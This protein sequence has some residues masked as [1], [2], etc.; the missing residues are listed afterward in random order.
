ML[1]KL[2]QKVAQRLLQS[3]EK[4]GG[5][6]RRQTSRRSRRRRS[7][8]TNGLVANRSI[9][10]SMVVE[11]S[12][13]TPV[14]GGPFLACRSCRVLVWFNSCATRHVQKSAVLTKALNLQKS[15]NQWR[16]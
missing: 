12:M 2:R 1:T 16:Y 11:V 5:C 13:Q 7:E 15:C 6:L 9:G 8:R 14:Q 3:R 4:V 10:V